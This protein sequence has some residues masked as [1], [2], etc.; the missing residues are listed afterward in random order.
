MG[1]SWT[2]DFAGRALDG[3][4]VEWGVTGVRRLRD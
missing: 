3:G 1:G 2:P 4:A